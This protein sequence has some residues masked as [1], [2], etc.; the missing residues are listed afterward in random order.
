MSGKQTECQKLESDHSEI[1][2]YSLFPLNTGRNLNPFKPFY[3][4]CATDTILSKKSSSGAY[5]LIG[6]LMQPRGREKDRDI[7]TVTIRDD[8]PYRVIPWL[9]GL[10]SMK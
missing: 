4:F 8:R 7:D 10:T 5:H 6:P 3:P 1:R 9:P 2:K